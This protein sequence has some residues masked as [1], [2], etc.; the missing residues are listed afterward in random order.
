MGHFEAGEAIN[1]V[2]SHGYLEGTI[3]TYDANDL[4]SV[5][6]QMQ[7]IAK[8]VSLLF[9]VDCQVKFEEGYPATM[10]SPQLR[11]T[12]EQAIVN[13]GL[14]VVEK[15]LPFL[16]GEDFSFYGQQLAPA[17]FAFVGTRNEAKNY[18]TGL[19]TSHLNFDERVLIYVADYYENLLKQYGEA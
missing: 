10:N 16:F 6:T 4:N 19:H 1:T 13:A 18:I 14:E 8:S 3:R 5:K 9:N 7:K 2:P 11:N 17:Y 12:V 15:P